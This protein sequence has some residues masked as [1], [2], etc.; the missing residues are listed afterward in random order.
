G[1]DIPGFIRYL[2]EGDSVSALEKIKKD[3]PFPAICGRICPAP[4]EGVCVFFEEGSPIAI[5]ALERYASDFGSKAMAR[6]KTTVPSNGKSVA[7]VGSGPS[8]MAAAS[9]L[10]MQG[11]KVVMFEAAGEP[12]GIL[13]YGIPEFRLPQDILASQFEELKSLGLELN[14]NNFIGSMKPFEEVITT[15][16][17]GVFATGASLPGFTTKERWKLGGVYYAEELLMRLLMVS[18]EKVLYSTKPLFR[19]NTTLVVGSGYAVLDVA[20]TALRLGQQTS[21]VFGGLEEEM[22]VPEQE[23]KDALEEGLK[24]LTP[25]EPL[26][27][28][29][30]GQGFVQG[31]QC[32]RLEIVEGA[33]S[34]SLA[35]VEEEPTI[36]EAQTVILAN[37]QKANSFLAKVVPHLKTKD[38]GS[39]WVDEKTFLTS[40]DKVFAVGSA[41]AGSMSVVQ[42]FA[43]GKAVALKVS[44]HLIQ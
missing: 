40:L 10:L 30:D 43:S 17:A 24:I 22:G 31:V 33:D 26:K 5:R 42:A 36:M 21:L 28:L 20:R 38:D 3:N 23:I 4:C 37:S 35:V 2:R 11:F 25:F 39:L 1:V 18:K 19:G 41:V 44:E 12:G 34:L 8:A 13:R 7:V 27:I 29:N 32:R 14:P 6:M 9:T 16:H 15:F